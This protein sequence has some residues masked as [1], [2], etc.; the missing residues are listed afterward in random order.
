MARIVGVHFRNA[1][2]VYYFDPKGL[3]V[4]MGDKL[5]VETARGLEM[6][7]ATLPPQEIPDDQVGKPLKDVVR[8]A[9]EEDL[10]HEEENRKKEDEAYKRC[11]ELI[12]KHNLEMKLVD[13]EYTFDNNKLLFYFTAEGRVD[14]RELVKDLASI[15]HTRIELR[16]IGVRDETKVLGGIGSCGRE[17]CCKTFLSDFAPVS[18]K[19]AK[20][21]GLS[22]NP[23]K[24]SGVCGRLMCCLKNE[25]ESY[26]YLN[27]LMPKIGDEVRT[28]ENEEGLVT[29]VNVLRQRAKVLFE[30]NDT[31]EVREYSV[32]ELSVIGHRKKGQQQKKQQEAKTG[33]EPKS[34]KNDG[35]KREERKPVEVEKTNNQKQDS[36]DTQPKK[37][38]RN[39]GRNKNKSN[40]GYNQANQNPHQ[41]TDRS[42]NNRNNRG[43]YNKNKNHGENQQG[44]AKS[45]GEN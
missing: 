40:G 12:A 1:G 10:K 23:T 22:L 37:N 42:K 28:E 35:K 11:K 2:K 32:E 5:I 26:E 19:M 43:N 38:N 24:I 17:L 21:Q 45:Q 31:R 7:S 9:T 27:S 44:G 8:L 18:I 16:Q 15:F 33:D 3:D 34:K 4:H 14:F 36:G 13:A 41:N 25:E 20:T 6:G 39:R 29:A 30:E